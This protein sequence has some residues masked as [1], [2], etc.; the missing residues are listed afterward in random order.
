MFNV[1]QAT[2]AELTRP[3]CQVFNSKL[4]DITQSQS[5]A[6]GDVVFWHQYQNWIIATKA[7]RSAFAQQRYDARN[8]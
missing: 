4:P 2:A 3:C 7:V 8:G 1:Q 5:L 6:C